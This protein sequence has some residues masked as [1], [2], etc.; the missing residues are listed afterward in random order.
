M[1]L[2]LLLNNDFPFVNTC[3]QQWLVRLDK[4]LDALFM[5]VS[6]CALR[7]ITRREVIATATPDISSAPP[8]VMPIGSC[9][10]STGSFRLGIG[11]SNFAKWRPAAHCWHTGEVIATGLR[12]A[13]WVR[14]EW[15][16]VTKVLGTEGA[17]QES[18]VSSRWQQFI[19]IFKLPYVWNKRIYTKLIKHCKNCW[20]LHNYFFP[21]RTS[22]A[23]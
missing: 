20:G 3:L 16:G 23:V 2:C 9:D 1:D 7:T 14:I 18:R 12:K 11:S 22:Y 6:V 4:L 19:T 5:Q 15:Q 17:V 13:I 8:N 10:P 21:K